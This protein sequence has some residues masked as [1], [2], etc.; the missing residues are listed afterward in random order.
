MNLPMKVL[1]QAKS[2]IHHATGFLETYMELTY[3]ALSDGHRGQLL[4]ALQ[5]L[6]ELRATTDAAQHEKAVQQELLVP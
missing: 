3:E 2:N 1:T 5:L 6:G 4:V